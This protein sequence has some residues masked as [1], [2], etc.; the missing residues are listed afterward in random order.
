MI[1]LGPVVARSRMR[2]ARAG[3]WSYVSDPGRRAEWWPELQLEPRIGGEI[4][5]RWSEGSG[6]ATVSRD[7]S[8]QVDVWVEG[9]AIGFTWREA[10]DLRDTA[11]LLTL[12]TQGSETG[13]TVTE[14]GFDALPAPAE[15]AAA[16]QQGWEVLLAALSKAI[17]GAV[18]AG[19]IAAGEA[20]KP[21]PRPS[22]E[23]EEAEEPGAAAEAPGA[24]E[25]E[26][27][28]ETV[29]V[30][31][32]PIETGGAP[33]GAIELAPEE[34]DGEVVEVETEISIEVDA[35]PQLGEHLE[36]DTGVVPVIAPDAA[37]DAEDP[38][39]SAT[40]QG[41]A[42]AHDSADSDEAAGASG[43]G[44]RDASGD[45]EAADAE[46]ADAAEQ[47]PAGRRRET[48]DASF[49]GDPDFDALIRGL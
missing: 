8:G 25:P 7:A 40:V 22:D 38:Q 26:T 16:S 6:D 29:P 32:L 27:N 23:A 33:A 39:G 12:R 37:P 44:E 1:P 18:A 46:A 47:K 20:P 21:E 35:E 34:I 2:A 15:R 30:E 13:V 10:G 43:T 17:D 49:T 19:T 9:H 36:L 48:D 3:V 42:A 14:T 45:A 41:S 5:E 4:A 28:D 11:V 31:R 24:V